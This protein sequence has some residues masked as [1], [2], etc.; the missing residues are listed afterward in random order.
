[1]SVGVSFLIPVNLPFIA[2][3]IV[4][5]SCSPLQSGIAATGGLAQNYRSQES[6][7]YSASFSIGIRYGASRYWRYG[8]LI[9]Q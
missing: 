9:W 8:W 7:C 6:D 5:F 2:L 3:F 4:R 1:M